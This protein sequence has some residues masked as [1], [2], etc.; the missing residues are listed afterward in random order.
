MFRSR[1]LIPLC[2]SCSVICSSATSTAGRL[3]VSADPTLRIDIP[4]KLETAKVVFNV[5]HLAFVGDMP[6][7]LRTPGSNRQGHQPIF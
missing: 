4:V 3:A 2:I 5:D 6:I 1:W 7:A